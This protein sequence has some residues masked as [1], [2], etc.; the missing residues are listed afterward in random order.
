M[1]PRVAGVVVFEADTAKRIVARYFDA[2]LPDHASQV[3]FEKSIIS[4]AVKSSALL[5]AAGIG[6]S[7]SS[8]NEKGK[9]S[10]AASSRKTEN[11]PS[12][13]E[14]VLVDDFLV[15]LRLVNDVLLAVIAREDQNDLLMAEYMA[16]FHNTLSAVL[17][18]N[19]CKKKIQ[20]RLDMVFLVIDESLERGYLFEMDP[21][22]IVSRINMD[23]DGLSTPVATGSPG[24][25]TMA[26]TASTAMREGIAAI[27]RGD[28]DSL[29]SV[30]AGAAQKFSNLLGR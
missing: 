29:R 8:G 15:L 30:F 5:A 7:S 28:A 27:S 12:S 1:Q 24:S 13:T 21:P 16:T 11:E 17:G 22:T 3:G 9:E 10:T 25:A 19:V 6:A 23:A 18:N 4:K 2:G 20:D 26:A 14:I